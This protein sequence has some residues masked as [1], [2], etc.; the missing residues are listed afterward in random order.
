MLINA[1]I[2]FCSINLDNNARAQVFRAF[3][4]IAAGKYGKVDDESD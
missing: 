3:R 2:C 1:I 4:S